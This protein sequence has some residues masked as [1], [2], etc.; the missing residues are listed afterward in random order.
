M[1]KETL[2][3]LGVIVTALLA[4]LLWFLR[5][6]HLK[7]LQKHYALC[8][9]NLR[10]LPASSPTRKRIEVAQKT[11]AL[12]WKVSK[13]CSGI[14]R[15][16]EAQRR[17]RDARACESMNPR[18]HTLRAQALSGPDPYQCLSHFAQAVEIDEL[19]CQWRQQFEKKVEKIG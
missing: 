12:G 13:A 7:S 4:L 11:F 3:G 10:R 14:L 9:L 16:Q 5:H 8:K 17:R 18:T 19:G 15:Q 6:Q 2:L 1:E